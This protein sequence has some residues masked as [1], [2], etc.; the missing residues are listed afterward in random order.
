MKR[1]V[2]VV[3]SPLRVTS[4]TKSSGEALHQLPNLDGSRAYNEMSVA[5]PQALVARRSGGA[6][7]T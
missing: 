7:M 5:A 6:I 4:D 1:Y 2:G 3:Q